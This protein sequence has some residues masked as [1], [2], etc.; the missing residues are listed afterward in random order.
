MS[1]AQYTELVC[2]CMFWWV[3]EHVSEHAYSGV[4]NSKREKQASVCQAHCCK[5]ASLIKGRDADL[6]DKY[7]S[8]L[9]SVP[10]NPKKAV[11]GLDTNVR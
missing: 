3:T 1:C 9:F 8:L 10:R 7:L 2:T 11:V 4:P 5:K 6:A